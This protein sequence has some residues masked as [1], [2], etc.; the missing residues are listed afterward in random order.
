M[1]SENQGVVDIL[2]PTLILL[3]H[4]YSVDWKG[5][6]YTVSD[7]PTLT[8]SL[9]P[10]SLSFTVSSCLFVSLW[11]RI[12]LC[13]YLP[14]PLCFV[15]HWNMCVIPVSKTAGRLSSFPCWRM[16][17][18]YGS[19]ESYR[20]GSVKALPVEKLLLAFLVGGH[21]EI[22]L[23]ALKMATYMLHS[24]SFDQCPFS[25]V[26]LT[27]HMFSPVLSLSIFLEHSPFSLLCF[28]FC[29]YFDIFHSFSLS[30][31]FSFFPIRHGLLS[32]SRQVKLA[33]GNC[34]SN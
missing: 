1:Q 9:S 31:F 17:G 12:C 18:H 32:L 19:C 15:C 34:W 24:F 26:M 11:H 30:L 29:L 10:L 2:L 8:E 3:T 21:S 23:L 13:I 20:L 33:D 28:F 4:L 6:N 14:L 22:V 7:T 25:F 16:R 27:C 5:E